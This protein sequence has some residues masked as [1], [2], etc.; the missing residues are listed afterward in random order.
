MLA[1]VAS[2]RGH[3]GEHFQVAGHGMDNVKLKLIEHWTQHT[4]VVTLK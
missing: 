4:L 1:F 3:C 2:F